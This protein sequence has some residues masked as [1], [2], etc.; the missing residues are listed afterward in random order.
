MHFY[1]ILSVSFQHTCLKKMNGKWTALKAMILRSTLVYWYCLER[2]IFRLTNRNSTNGLHTHAYSS[3]SLTSKSASFSSLIYPG[4]FKGH[5]PASNE[6]HK[7]VLGFHFEGQKCYL[8]RAKRRER[9]EIMEVI[10]KINQK[11]RALDR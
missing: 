10:M 8:E 4:T 9:G 1:S 7:C 5:S 6:V 11:R 2:K 3:C